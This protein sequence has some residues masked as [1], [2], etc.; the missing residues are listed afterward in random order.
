MNG[1]DEIL[2]VNR[3]NGARILAAINRFEAFVNMGSISVK[4]FVI[5]NEEL[6]HN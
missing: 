6:L 4:R 2:V 3:H 1:F 5:I